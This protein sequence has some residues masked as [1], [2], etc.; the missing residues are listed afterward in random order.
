MTAD[1]TRKRLADSISKARE[2]RIRVIQTVANWSVQQAMFKPSP[3]GWCA[4]EILEHLY[5]SEFNLNNHI[6]KAWDGW[7]RREPVWVGEHTNQG[8]PI[9][10]ILGPH[11]NG[12]YAAPLLEEPKFGGPLRF[13][14][15]ALGSCQIQ[16]ERLALLLGEIDL[17]LLVFP[18]FVVG[19]LDSTQWLEFLPF[20]IDRHRRQIE[21]LKQS[22][23]FPA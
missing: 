12:K 2:A 15:E 1:G 11:A 17:E 18:H 10:E 16:L 14:M 22:E 6:W 9:L 8:R 23:E 21:R 7:R 4:S 3:E 13:W 5:L 20:H 19:P